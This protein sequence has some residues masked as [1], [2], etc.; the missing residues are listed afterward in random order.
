MHPRLTAGQRPGPPTGCAW[1]CAALLGVVV[2]GD[3]RRRRRRR[4][5]DWTPGGGTEHA[6]PVLAHRRIGGPDPR[7]V[8]LHGLAGSGRYWGSEY[9][10][11]ASAGGVIVPDLAGFGRSIDAPGPYD[12][13]GHADAVAAL[14]ELTHVGGPVVVAAHSFGTN[15]AVALAARHPELVTAVVAFGP[16]WYADPEAARARLGRMGPMARAFALDERWSHRV[17]EWVCDHRE[18]AARLAVVA[19]RDLPAAV[20]AD[21]VRH[22][23][24]SYEQTL[25]SILAAEVAEHLRTASAPIIVVAGD[26][27]RLTDEPYLRRLASAG[28]IRFDTWHG[29]HDIPLARGADCATLIGRVLGSSP[30]R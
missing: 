13:T 11:C 1:A 8:L 23:W 12:L 28:R 15:V 27:D 2:A 29:D 4:A 7:V 6:G 18:L 22:T 19:R 9:D 24:A 30:R 21:G 3:A 17:C 25:G 26:R 20:A 14:L 5:L 16:P 10:A